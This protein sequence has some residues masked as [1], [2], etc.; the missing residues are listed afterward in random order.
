MYDRLILWNP[1]S[2]YVKLSLSEMETESTFSISTG[3]EGKKSQMPTIQ[4]VMY[5]INVC[6]SVSLILQ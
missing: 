2:C 1:I 5:V 4:Y 3:S 6:H